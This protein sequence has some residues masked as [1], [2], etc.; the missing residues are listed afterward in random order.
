M[1]ASRMSTQFCVDGDGPW[2]LRAHDRARIDANRVTLAVAFDDER[3]RRRVV[4]EAECVVDL[5][6]GEQGRASSLTQNSFSC[7]TMRATESIAA[8]A[9]T[10][11]NW[12][13]R[14]PTSDRY[15]GDAA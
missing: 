1:V 10:R 2:P 14:A 9:D 11:P 3:D 13:T 4:A 12:M 5:R 6:D 8:C 7:G 15:S